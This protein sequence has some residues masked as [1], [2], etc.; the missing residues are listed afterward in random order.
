[1]IT[2]KRNEKFFPEI[3]EITYEG[4]TSNNPLAFKFYDA[5]KKVAGKSMKDHFRFAMAYWHTLCGTG[6]DPFGPG[7]KMCALR[8]RHDG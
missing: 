6:G 1:M 8:Y 5:D 7:T 2:L 3:G 4:N